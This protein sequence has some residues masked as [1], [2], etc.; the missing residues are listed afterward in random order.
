M[1]DQTVA[2]GQTVELKDGRVALVRFF[3]PTLFSDGNW[4]GVELEDDS[5]KNDGS[6]QGVRYFGCDE[7]RGMFLR[8]TGISRVLDEPARAPVEPVEEDDPEEEDGEEE[9]EDDEYLEE[10]ERPSSAMQS[11]PVGAFRASVRPGVGFGPSSGPATRSG[12]SSLNKRTSMNPPSPGPV[13]RTVR[14]GLKVGIH[15]SQPARHMLI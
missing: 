6:V 7:G 4:V 5:G 8:I 11:R 9:E 13:S 2:P 1:A 3:G 10:E 14:S 15:S 12:S